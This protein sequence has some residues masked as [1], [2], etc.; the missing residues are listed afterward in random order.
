MK[1]RAEGVIPLLERDIFIH[2]FFL[3]FSPFSHSLP[4]LLLL[5]K[6]RT[7]NTELKGDLKENEKLL[8]NKTE[9]FVQMEKKVGDLEQKLMVWLIIFE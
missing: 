3:F 9:S 1:E 8:S 5:Q 4:S 7:E 2:F 6:L